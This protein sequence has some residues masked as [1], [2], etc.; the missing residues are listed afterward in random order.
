M[1]QFPPITILPPVSV[2]PVSFA[3]APGLIVP[4]QLLLRLGGVAIF[5]P[6]VKVSTTPTP[7]RLVVVLGLVMVSFRVAFPPT[8]I[9][10]GVNDLLMLGGIVM[11]SVALAALPGPV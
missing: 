7:V 8:G 11:V 4:L 1:V 9:A 10:A 2:I 5:S 3:L 6:P